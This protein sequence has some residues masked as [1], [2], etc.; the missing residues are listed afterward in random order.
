VNGKAQGNEETEPSG[1]ATTIFVNVENYKHNAYLMSDL[2]E[3]LIVI[4]TTIWRLQNLG[5]GCR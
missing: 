2:L 3:G 1:T 5:R 4:R